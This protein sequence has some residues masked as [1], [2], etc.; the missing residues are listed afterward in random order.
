MSIVSIGIGLSQPIT[1][2]A[3][4]DDKADARESLDPPKR[5][6]IPI[7]SGSNIEGVS[8]DCGAFVDIHLRPDIFSRGML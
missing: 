4:I 8:I 1:A 6:I 5:E 3:P 7:E 2:S